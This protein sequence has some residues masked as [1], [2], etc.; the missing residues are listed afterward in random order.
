MKKILTGLIAAMIFSAMALAKPDTADARWGY[1]YRGAGYRGVAYR[2]YGYR[3]V[4][5]VVL[6][7]EG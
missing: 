7:I 6:L 4:G 5:T 3:G 2:G 1:G